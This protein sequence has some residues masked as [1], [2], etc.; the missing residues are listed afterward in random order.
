MTHPR[1]ATQIDEIIDAHLETINL[2]R[3]PEYAAKLSAM[4]HLQINIAP[5]VMRLIA[6]PDFHV[7]HAVKEETAR[8]FAV[9]FDDLSKAML[10]SWLVSEGDL[11]DEEAATWLDGFIKDIKPVMEAVRRHE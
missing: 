10:G 2:V 9:D 7:A 11:S 6:S 5:A 8:Q 4:L 3:G 1:T